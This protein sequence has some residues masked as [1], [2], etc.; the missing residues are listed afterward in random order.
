LEE[1]KGFFEGQDYL[2]RN[3]ATQISRLDF[4]LLGLPKDRMFKNIEHS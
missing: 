1:I 4:F 3:L 2:D